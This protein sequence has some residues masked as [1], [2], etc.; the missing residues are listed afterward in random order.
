MVLLFFINLKKFGIYKET[1]YR[2]GKD[3]EEVKVDVVGLSIMFESKE[4]NKKFMIVVSHLKS[5][6]D[7]DGETTRLQ[8][9]NHLLPKVKEL[10]EM[11]QKEL[12]ENIP[13]FFS[14]DLN[15]APINS[16][17]Y[18]PYAYYSIVKSDEFNELIKKSEEQHANNNDN[19]NIP[20][21]PPSSNYNQQLSNE[22]DGPQPQTQRLLTTDYDDEKNDK[23]NSWFTKKKTC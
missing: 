7:A 8:Q 9:L 3:Y 22:D 21:N 16:K 17:G 13:I 14:A 10:N 6:K 19:D 1:I 12:K 5:A 4:N 20:I 2:F 23:K 18:P 15:A 11:I